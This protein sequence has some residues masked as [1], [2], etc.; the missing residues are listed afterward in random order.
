MHAFGQGALKAADFFGQVAADDAFN[1]YQDRATKLL[2]GDPNA[3]GSDGQRG[4]DT[5]YL[6]LKGQAALRA[7]PAVEAQLDDLQKEIYGNLQTPQQQYQF[8]TAS[9]RYRMAAASQI[10][11]HADDQANTWYTQVNG[12][13]EKNALDY[14][15]NNADDP[16]LVAS[17]TAELIQARVKQAQLNGAQPG[18]PVFQEAVTGGKRDGLKTWV[19]AVGAT[20]PSG[21]LRILGKNRNLA[22]VD[23]EPLYN[24]LIEKANTQ[25]AWTLG[26][27]TA[28]QVTQQVAASPANPAQPVYAQTAQAIPGGMSA[29]GLARTVQIESGGR[30]VDNAIGMMGYGQ[31]SKGTWAQFGANGDPHNLQDSVAA[32]QRYGAYNARAFTSAM[33]RPPTDAELYMMHQQGTGGGMALLSNPNANAARL[34]GADAIT[35]N[36]GTTSMTAGQFTAMWAHKFNGTTPAEGQPAVPLQSRAALAPVNPAAP[37][38]VPANGIPTTVPTTI[39]DANANVPAAPAGQPVPVTDPQS[40]KA[41]GYQ[42]IMD[43]DASPEVKQK[44]LSILNQQLAAMQIAADATTAQRK[45]ESDKAADG[46]M[47]KILTG[48]YTPDLLNSIA[49]DP[50]LEWQ[51]KQS[52][53]NAMLAHAQ[54]TSAGATAA[55]G[56][57]FWK[58]FQQVNAPPGDPSRISDVSSILNRAGP[59]GD[60]NLSGAKELVSILGTNAR[61]VDDASV[62]QAKASLMQYAKS[63]LSFQQDTGPIQIKDPEGERLF[64]ARFVPK[65]LAAF[66]AATKEG[67]DPWREFL[68]QDNV[69]KMLAGLRS[70]REMALAQLSAETTGVDTS[71]LVA[72]PVPPGVNEEGWKVV[73]NTVPPIKLNDGSQMPPQNWQIAVE[74]LQADPTPRTRQ[75]FDAHFAQGNVTAAAILDILGVRTIAG[76][77]AGPAGGPI[78]AP[79]PVIQSV[80]AAAGGGG[81]L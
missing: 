78:P 73:M 75:L 2:H 16:K 55:Y 26:T 60:L 76:Q 10:G 71:Q 57:G 37:Q 77:S 18:D 15:A 62:N 9:R 50:A 54:D 81:G 74:R 79:V 35:G 6:G 63:K 40:A 48:N 68:T 41:A 21:A 80:P 67:K 19:Q 24:S 1:Q 70:P 52:L 31:F 23:Y 69:D 11:S 3:I 64:S 72:P 61:S 20:D 33:G 44:A 14:I 28:H 66:D 56:Q 29:S 36:G 22:G 30:P 59:G 51:T 53:N 27:S 47:T 45:Q 46:Y 32:I 49:A 65:F 42:A 7:R 8:E 17:G 39:P 4:T 58:A 5:G 38:S 34:V 25:D 43:S 13:S 12:T